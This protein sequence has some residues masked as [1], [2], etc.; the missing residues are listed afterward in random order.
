MELSGSAQNN[1]EIRQNLEEFAVRNK[2]D[3]VYW[4]EKSGRGDDVTLYG[5]PLH[6]GE[7]LE[8]LLYTRKSSVVMT[9]AT[10]AA[11][12]TFDH[13]QERTGFVDSEQRL[14]GSP[15]DFPN[16]ALVCVPND[17]PEPSAPNYMES[18]AQAIG[19]TAIAAG[20]RTMALFTSYASLREAA[21]ALR[22]TMKSQGSISLCRGTT[23][24][25][26]RSSG[27]FERIH[28]NN[29]G[30]GQLLGGHRPR[31]GFAAGAGRHAA[32]VQRAH[33][34]GV[35]GAVGAL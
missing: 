21:E 14:L 31:G 3:V 30:D 2:D 23:A 5:A 25:R 10:L 35:R 34:A 32:A 1:A 29:L 6:V 7:L 8:E 17:M 33:R 22:G 18:A 15:F 24:A 26:T 11:N 12:G 4:V 27:A 20:G 9:S 13:I 19:D 28:V 16:S